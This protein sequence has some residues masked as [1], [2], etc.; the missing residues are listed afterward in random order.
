MIE[1]YEQLKSGIQGLFIAGLTL[2]AISGCVDGCAKLCGGFR[3]KENPKLMAISSREGISYSEH[4]GITYVDDNPIGSLDKVVDYTLNGEIQIR[5]LTN[6]T[7]K[8]YSEFQRLR[9]ATEEKN[10][11]YTP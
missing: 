6:F 1:T 5:T 4:P 7:A 2:A 9:R 3:T 8:D 11:A 10:R